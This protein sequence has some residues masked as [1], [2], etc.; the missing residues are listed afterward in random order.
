MIP[1]C[2][3]GRLSLKTFGFFVV[4]FLIVCIVI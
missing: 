3:T 1:H 4:I 2:R